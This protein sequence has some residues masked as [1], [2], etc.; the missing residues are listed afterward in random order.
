MGGS[1]SGTGHVT[2]LA[3]NYMS[4]M[5]FELREG[6]VVPV[7][8]SREW[9]RQRKELAKRTRWA[10]LSVMFGAF[11]MADVLMFAMC[12]QTVKMGFILPGMGCAMMAIMYAMKSMGGQD[13]LQ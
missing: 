9:V 13:G 5:K 7:K 8:I 10:L 12:P 3:T 1:S 6:V 2:S 4:E 11:A